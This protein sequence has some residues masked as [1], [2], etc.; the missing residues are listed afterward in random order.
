MKMNI[1]RSFKTLLNYSLLASAFAFIS[2][3]GKAQTQYHLTTNKM[4][5]EGTSNI[6]DWSMQ[7]SSATG[8]AVITTNPTNLLT[9]LANVNFSVPVETLKSEKSGLDKNAYKALK[10]DKFKSIVFHA[11]KTTIAPASGNTYNLSAA[12]KLTISGVARDVVLTAVGVMAGDKS[13]NVKGA[14]KLKMT[15][16][17]VE[18]PSLMFGAIKTA[19]E[20]TLRYEIVFKP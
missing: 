3:S 2:F 15:D 17:S 11:V 18:P 10:T 20:V 9:D 6:H 13:I 19:D 12:G 14:Y 8:G 5:I 1:I 4:T 7:S 16:Y